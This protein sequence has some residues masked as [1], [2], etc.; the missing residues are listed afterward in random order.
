MTTLTLT[1]FAK[2][3]YGVFGQYRLMSGV[4]QFTLEPI[5]CIPTDVYQC[6]PARYNRGG[7]DSSLITFVP[8]RTNIKH[9][10]GNTMN[11]TTGCILHGSSLGWL[12]G[13]WAVINSTRA[14][15][16]FMEDYGESDFWLDIRG[17]N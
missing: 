10:I 8:G 5:N 6:R 2:T 1:R 7:Y 15:S 4:Q 14:F 11:D 9:H 3:P 16:R 17:I 13:H 12:A